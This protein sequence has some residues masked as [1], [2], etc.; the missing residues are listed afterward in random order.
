MNGLVAFMLLQT[1]PAVAQDDIDKITIRTITMRPGIYM[2]D[3]V[4]G[5]GGGN[6]TVA[7]G[8]DG[9]LLVD[10]MFVP[11]MPK[12]Q[13]TLKTLSDKPIRF[14]INSHFHLDHIA[15][16]ATLDRRTTLIA[17]ENV[18]KRLEAS[19]TAAA[20]TTELLPSFTISDNATLYFN[21]EKIRLIHLPNGHT[22]ADLVVYFTNSKVAQMGDM[23]F[24]GMFPG[25]YAQGG[26]NIKQLIVNLELILKEIAPDT[27]VVPGHGDTATVP[28]LQNYVAMLK[29]TTSIVEEGIKKGKSLDQ[30]TKEK[31]LAK[32]DALGSGGAQTTDQYLNMVYGLLSSGK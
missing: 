7:V 30:L 5:F 26:G 9:I 20:P 4:G 19:H 24:F 32:Y 25:I 18:R 2:L 14:A 3:C 1:G 28:D 22:D 13:A 31:V 27:K 21:G 16:N 8:E 10:N 12:V 23:F 17:H 11:M 15:G 29:E 6:I